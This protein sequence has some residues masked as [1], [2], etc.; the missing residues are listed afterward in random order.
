MLEDANKPDS[1]KGK[2]IHPVD[3][4]FQDIAQKN[5]AVIFIKNVQAFLKKGGYCHLAV[6]ARSIDVTRKPGKIFNEIKALLRDKFEI[7]DYRELDPF[8]KDHAYFVC[9]KR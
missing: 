6:K 4:I 1:Y 7:V 5:Q 9:K 3:F 8:E 2:I